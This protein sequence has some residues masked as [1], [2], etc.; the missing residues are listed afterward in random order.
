VPILLGRPVWFPG[1]AW[2]CGYARGFAA[3]TLR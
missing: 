3:V 1:E 2:G